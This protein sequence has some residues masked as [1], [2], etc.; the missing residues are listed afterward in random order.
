MEFDPLQILNEHHRLNGLFA[1]FVHGQLFY[2]YQMKYHVQHG[3]VLGV[4]PQQ[5]LIHE[6]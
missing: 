2:H 6:V 4:S 5:V 3:Y 1:L